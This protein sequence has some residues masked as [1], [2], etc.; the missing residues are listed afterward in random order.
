MKQVINTLVVA[1]TLAITSATAGAAVRTH[2]KTILVESPAEVPALAQNGSEA[3]YLYN[4]G[5]GRAVLYVE[6]TGGRA[7]SALD[8]TNPANIKLVT[9]T[10]L[11]APSAF[12][13]VQEVGDNGTLIRY[14]NG[15]GVAL[16]S[17][18]QYQ[19]PVLV[20][21]PALAQ[22]SVSETIG[23]TG[24]LL[25][26]AE[27]A[28]AAPVSQAHIY[29]VLDTTNP[30]QPGM[31]AIVPAVK[32]RLAKSDTG[33]LFLLNNDGVTVVRQPQVE[34]ERQIELDQQMGN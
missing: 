1:A 27:V 11:A 34:E 13:F 9:Q 33:T 12:D 28:T 6:A 22:T 26:S 15:S 7:L 18:R 14:R 24:L 10:P 23:Q 3:M 20:A 8:V 19:H 30:S 32:E 29:N 21:Q 16:I 25:T 5:D 31:L 2:S 17:F 4:T